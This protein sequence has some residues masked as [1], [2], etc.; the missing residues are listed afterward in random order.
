MKR[1]AIVSRSL[2]VLALCGLLV[3]MVACRN[4]VEPS[5]DAMMTVEDQVGGAG[6]AGISPENPP[7]TDLPLDIAPAM[8][9][10]SPAVL[11]A[12]LYYLNPGGQIMRLERDGVTSMPVTDD[13]HVQAYDVSPDGKTLAYVVDN[14]LILFDVNSG[15]RT[16][17]IAGGNFAPDDYASQ[18]TKTI[19]SPRFSPDGTQIAFGMGGINIAGLTPDS[20][21]TLI[22]PS[23]P[24]PDFSTESKQPLSGPVRFFSRAEWS[25]DGTR[26][27]ISF[28]YF[29]EGGGLAVKDLES[30]ALTMVENGGIYC[31]D[32][33]WMGDATALIGSNLMV[34]A[35]PGLAQVDTK[36]GAGMTLIAG[37]DEAG[38][39]PETP[40]QLVRA[41]FQAD[42][43]SV[44][45]FVG[46]QYGGDFSQ[47]WY[48]LRRMD[49]AGIFTPITPALYQLPGDVQWISGGSG[50]VFVNPLDPLVQATSSNYPLNNSMTWLPSRGDGALLLPV[51]GHEPRWGGPP[52]ETHV[53][54]AA[55]I[56]DLKAKAAADFGIQPE[57]Q[58]IGV[59][60]LTT[61]GSRI[62]FVAFS[63]G[64]HS[65]DPLVNHQVAIYAYDNGWQEL[66]RHELSNDDPAVNGLSPDY[67]GETS[68]KQVMVEPG[69][70]WLALDGGVGAHSGVFLLL[71]FDGASLT[72]VT[73]NF[74]A[75]P[76]AGHVADINGDG[77]GEVLL[78]LSE[79]YVFYYAAGVRLVQYAILHWDGTQ[80][81]PVQLSA[82]PDTVA[83]DVR[84]LNKRAITF[85]EAG[86]WKDAQAAIAEAG[87]MAADN[88]MVAW[89]AAFINYNGDARRMAGMVGDPYPLLTYVFYGDYETAVSV[90]RGYSAARLFSDASPLVVG[91]VAEGMAAE[92]GQ[93]LVMNAG[94]ALTVLPDLAPAYF[95]RAWGSYLLDSADPTIKADLQ[96]AVELAPD[97]A[98]YAEALAMWP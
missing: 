71:N 21:L 78:N 85:A 28:G 55:A 1:S 13:A 79:P 53:P 73:G 96:K 83:P 7:I 49:D 98:L 2:L 24:Y 58:G 10:G 82:L 64:M 26:L 50:L 76:D 39:S 68:V 93:M 65:F 4:T 42:D 70:I 40:V 5:S 95:I 33:A 45:A 84:E 29:P 36:T 59:N 54:D 25:P 46:E 19:T 52:Q 12:P 22:Q 69:R 61:D 37:Y 47:V 89:N 44:Y 32:L 17:R 48:Q 3:V 41:P 88:Q 16:V 86:L 31:C 97:D 75:S 81:V 15:A 67:V 30:G 66:A 23:D 56:A 43:G 18:A 35:M 9:T 63:T 38:A 77:L 6:D 80:L 87:G 60:Q 91:T 34:Y 11:P 57:T 51:V 27:L 92:L 74:N 8:Q 62:L 94:S 90:M 14:N 20:P 72:T